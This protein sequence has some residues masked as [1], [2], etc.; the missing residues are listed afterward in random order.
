MMY[1]RSHAR[2]EARGPD[3]G[4]PEESPARRFVGSMFALVEGSEDVLQAI[5]EMVQ[6]DDA[7][8]AALVCTRFRDSIFSSAR[9]QRTRAHRGFHRTV[10][11]HWP[12]KLVTV[13]SF[14]RFLS[15]D[16]P[17]HLRPLV[18]N[19]TGPAAGVRLQTSADAVIASRSRVRWAHSLPD[20]PASFR[21]EH[22]CKLAAARGRVDILEWA[23]ENGWACDETIL[24]HAAGGGHLGMLQYLCVHPELRRLF[25]SEDALLHMTEDALRGDHV[26]VLRWAHENEY[27]TP[28]QRIRYRTCVDSAERGHLGAVQWLRERGYKWDSNSGGKVLCHQAAQ[29]GHLNILQ[30]ARAHGAEWCSETTRCAAK[31][32]RLGV[33]KWARSNGCPCDVDSCCEEAIYHEHAA[34]WQWAIGQADCALGTNTIEYA[35]KKG[36]R[37]AEVLEWAVQQAVEEGRTIP[38]LSVACAA[39]GGNLEGLKLLLASGCKMDGIV[40]DLAFGQFELCVGTSACG[41][42]LEL[43]ERIREIGCH[44][45]YVDAGGEPIIP[46]QGRIRPFPDYE[47][48][49]IREVW[50]PGM[51]LPSDDNDYF[52][53][54][55][56]PPG[57]GPGDWVVWPLRTSWQQEFFPDT[58]T[59]VVPRG[60][61]AGEIFAVSE[62]E[63]FP[64][65]WS[66]GMPLPWDVRDVQEEHTMRLQQDNPYVTFTRVTCPQGKGPLDEL[67]VPVPTVWQHSDDIGTALTFLAV[68]PRGIASGEVFAVSEHV[69]L[70]PPVKVECPPDMGPGDVMDLEVMSPDTGEFT[71]TV[72]VPDEIAAGEIFLVPCHDVTEGYWHEDKR[73]EEYKEGELDEDSLAEK[74]R[75]LY[76]W[77]VANRCPDT[78]REQSL[79][80]YCA[81]MPKLVSAEASH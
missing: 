32:G 23:R 22:I 40:L 33:L 81:L 51:P 34:V 14:H 29:G 41:T 38:P 31:G 2:R 78:Y 49:G 70:S 9:F 30:W 57:K 13:D 46:A 18:E 66:P 15:Q 43:L 39:D 65:T 3:G 25:Q 16:L 54:V 64:D 52:T 28:F 79:D 60:I 19:Y 12:P 42:H 72:T 45:G 27:I 76:T 61:T 48:E 59:A 77:A 7:L 80:A 73:I 17:S 8:C 5:F 75:A 55:T 10:H 36:E 21:E 56:C 58:F 71:M 20:C 69:A 53:K 67:E 11:A 35:A 68:V 50:S 47:D 1:T 74:Y 63:V 44:D 26:N 6:P 24:R 37:Y 62:Q 4:F